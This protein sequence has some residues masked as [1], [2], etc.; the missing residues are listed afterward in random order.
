MIVFLNWN[1]AFKL[2]A[3]LLSYTERASAPSVVSHKDIGFW[4]VYKLFLLQLVI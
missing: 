1:P 4:N 3:F 2:F